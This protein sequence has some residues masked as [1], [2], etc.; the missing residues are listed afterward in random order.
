MRSRKKPLNEKEL[1]VTAV[2]KI[3]V[4]VAISSSLQRLPLVRQ[5]LY[6][7]GPCRRMLCFHFQHPGSHVQSDKFSF[8]IGRGV[9]DVI[10]AFAY[11]RQRSSLTGCRG[12]GSA[13]ERLL[14]DF[15][16]PGFVHNQERFSRALL[17]VDL[18]SGTV[19]VW[20]RCERS[21]KG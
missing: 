12:D 19:A 10:Q 5:S 20:D 11:G 15:L 4:V 1:N 7:H 14:V 3:C 21:W 18:L 13:R 17:S 9:Y 8:L 6:H 2:N 16:L